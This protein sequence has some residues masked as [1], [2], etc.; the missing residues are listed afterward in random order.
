M[1]FVVAV[2]PRPRARSSR[3]SFVRNS[4]SRGKLQ[5]CDECSEGQQTLKFA[6]AFLEWHSASQRG[7]L[8][9]SH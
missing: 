3:M 5:G 7:M 9:H 8:A 2:V 4:I 6:H 1:F